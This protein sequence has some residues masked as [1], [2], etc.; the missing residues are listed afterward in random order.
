[1]AILNPFTGQYRVSSEYGYRSA[2]TAGSS[3][4]HKGIDYAMPVNTDILSSIAGRVAAAGFNSSRGNYV[5]IDN[6]SGVSTLYQHLN[7]ILVK[8]GDTV[9]Q[10]QL[11]AKSGNTGTSTG[12][13][14]HYELKINGQN[15]DPAL[16]L[17]SYDQISGDGSTAAGSVKLPELDSVTAAIKKYWYL[18][19]A[20][21]LAVGLIDK[22]RD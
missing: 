17:Q 2:P 10:G 22:L 6:D 14:L 3:T 5:I 13:H 12:P 18:I 11:I 4:D 8:A 1:M 7:S 15:V 19:A 16:Y 9:R 21:L 20:G